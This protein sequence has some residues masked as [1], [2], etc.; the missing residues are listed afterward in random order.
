MEMFISAWFIFTFLTFEGKSKTKDVN[1][2][3]MNPYKFIN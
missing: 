2:A 3:L 1:T